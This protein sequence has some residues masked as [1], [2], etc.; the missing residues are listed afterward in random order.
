[1]LWLCCR[2]HCIHSVTTAIT[3]T[4]FS[5]TSFSVTTA[6]LSRPQLQYTLGLIR[7]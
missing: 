7:E 1:M 5:A 3:A 6:G 2:V 4:S